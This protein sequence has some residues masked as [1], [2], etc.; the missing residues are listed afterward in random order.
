MITLCT[1]DVWPS[2][3]C[4]VSVTL[5]G[6]PDEMAARF[7]HIGGLPPRIST[8]SSAQNFQGR[9]QGLV[10]N[11]ERILDEAHLKQIDYEGEVEVNF[12]LSPSAARVVMITLLNCRECEVPT[13]GGHHTQTCLF[14]LSPHL[15]GS[16]QD[17]GLQPGGYLLPAENY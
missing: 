4:C 8:T 17:E 6:A 2:V 5:H 16:S 13:P 9:I 15:P 10:I 1:V 7:Y 14:H 11:G 3:D 12:G